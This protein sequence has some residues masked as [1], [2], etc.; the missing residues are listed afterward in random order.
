MADYCCRDAGNWML[1]TGFSMLDAGKEL[2]G[3]GTRRASSRI[4]AQREEWTVHDKT[5]WV[6]GKRKAQDGR[7]KK[8]KAPGARLSA[9]GARSNE[10]V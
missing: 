3:A 5:E 4:K 1:D 10:H 7:W 2:R 6:K 8:R 9:H